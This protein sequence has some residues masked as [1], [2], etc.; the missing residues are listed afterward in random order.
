[1]QIA[2]YL[3][4]FFKFDYECKFSLKFKDMP[5]EHI[6]KI[7]RDHG[8]MS[9]RKY[10]HDKRVYLGSLKYMPHAILKLMENMPMPWEQVIIYSSCFSQF[11]T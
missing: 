4:F 11:N 6:R 1:M 3:I 9:S 2:F 7:I 5:P 10:R 8:D